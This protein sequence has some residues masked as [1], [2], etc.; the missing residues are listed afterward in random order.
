MLKELLLLYTCHY[1][2]SINPACNLSLT[3]SLSP[4]PNPVPDSLSESHECSAAKQMLV[5]NSGEK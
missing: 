4:H 3:Y 2:P 5:P 1:C